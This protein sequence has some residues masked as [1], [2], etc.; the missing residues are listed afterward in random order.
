METILQNYLNNICC[1]APPITPYNFDV[2]SSDWAGV[3][4][5]DKASF[6]SALVVTCG[7]FAITGNKIEAEILTTSFDGANNVLELSSKNIINV[8]YIT[9]NMIG[10]I[11]LGYNQITQFNPTLPL[12]SNLKIL[13]ID[14][15]GLT[16]FNPT[17]PLPSNLQVL[18]IQFNQLTEFNPP[19]SLP[20]SLYRLY[21]AGNQMT[22]A[23][24]TISESWANLQTPFTPLN[25]SVCEIIFMFN[26]DSVA[27]TNLQAILSTKNT[28]ITV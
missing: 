10:D 1:P 26:I 22:L 4:I 21:L 5:T 25:E 7:A 28:F 13:V 12:P 24:Y 6:E 9:A 2:E 16:Q 3:G 15:N 11:R 8:N 23:G 14:F 20:N 17:L 19:F 27:G 18:S